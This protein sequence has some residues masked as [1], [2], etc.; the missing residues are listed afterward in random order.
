MLKIV[1][2]L[3]LLAFA[4]LMLFVARLLFGF[5]LGGINLSRRGVRTTGTC[6]GIAGGRYG[7]SVVVEST[8]PGGTRHSAMVAGRE[9]GVLPVPGDSVEIVYSPG[10]PQNAE[11]WPPGPVWGKIL[12]LSIVGPVVIGSGVVPVLLAVYLIRTAL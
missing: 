11:R 9:G 8:G 6:T 5:F 12:Y 4:A 1:V 3:A 7:N 2:S 10:D